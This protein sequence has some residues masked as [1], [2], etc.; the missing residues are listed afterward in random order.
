M[1]L[2]VTFSSSLRSTRDRL[3]I[4][5]AALARRLDVSMQTVNNWERGRCVPRD[6]REILAQLEIAA[7]RRAP[8]ERIIDRI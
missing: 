7:P 6:A 5:Q 1:R 8:V 2:K 3:G 4:T